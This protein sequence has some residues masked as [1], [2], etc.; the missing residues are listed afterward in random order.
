MMLCT[1]EQYHF[2]RKYFKKS[3]KTDGCCLR[4]SQ[5]EWA[6]WVKQINGTI[7][8]FDKNFNQ[9]DLFVLVEGVGDYAIAYY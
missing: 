2:V 1:F 9:N 8:P 5:N 7:V 4:R 6:F 3:T